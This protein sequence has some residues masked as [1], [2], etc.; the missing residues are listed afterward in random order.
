MRDKMVI[1]SF[2]I[3]ATLILGG[4]SVFFL[5]EEDNDG[6]IYGKVVKIEATAYCPCGS[7]CDWVLNAKGHPVHSTGKNRGKP[8]IGIDKTPVKTG[9]RPPDGA[10]RPGHPRRK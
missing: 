1:L 6:L 3:L 9:N 7:C 4:C 10:K 8:H 5:G 2:A